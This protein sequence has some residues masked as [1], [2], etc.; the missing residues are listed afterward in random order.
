MH[1]FSKSSRQNIFWCLSKLG[2]P[3][4]MPLSSSVRRKTKIRAQ[5]LTLIPAKWASYLTTYMARG[6]LSCGLRFLHPNTDPEASPRRL[7]RKFSHH[8]DVIQQKHVAAPRMLVRDF[9]YG[10]M[11]GFAHMMLDG[12]LSCG[13]RFLHPNTDPEASPRR[14]S[15]KFSHHMDVIQQ[16]HVAAPRMLVRDFAYGRMVGFAHMMLDGPLSCGLRF[17]HP[18]TDPEASPRRLSRKFSHHMDVIEQSRK[19]S[20]FSSKFALFSSNFRPSHGSKFDS[21]VVLRI[22]LP[23]GMLRDLVNRWWCADSSV[24]LP[25]SN[26]RRE[27]GDSGG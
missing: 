6:P 25:Q 9:A 26:Y 13:L 11:V 5:R 22:W 12:P 24:G 14:L 16:K 2:S 17:L 18:N 4:W 20:C 19:I 27:S 7:S 21:A 1:S 3:S 8:M 10:R 15:R 23:K